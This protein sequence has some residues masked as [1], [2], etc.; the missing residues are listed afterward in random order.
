[1]PEDAS[2]IL[3]FEFFDID[4]NIRDTIQNFHADRAA[5]NLF[6]REAAADAL[7]RHVDLDEARER[8]LEAVTDALEARQDEEGIFSFNEGG[9]FFL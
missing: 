5:G 3:G 6:L 8:A 4:D 1:M 7:G 9:D 2:P